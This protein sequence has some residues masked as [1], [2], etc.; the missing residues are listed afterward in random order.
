MPASGAAEKSTG[1]RNNRPGRRKHLCSSILPFYLARFSHFRPIFMEFI[2]LRDPDD[3]LLTRH[4]LIAAGIS[5]AAPSLLGVSIVLAGLG[6]EKL[7]NAPFFI[8][9]LF[10]IASLGAMY[11]LA[12]ETGGRLADD[13]AAKKAN[14]LRL[15]ILYGAALGL[16]GGGIVIF[17][18]VV[19]VFLMR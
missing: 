13:A 18:A 1:A 3:K 10:S 19:A 16:I 5:A 2:M 12:R 9:F 17:A 11:L 4:I 14:S 7:S 8:A 6:G 15:Q